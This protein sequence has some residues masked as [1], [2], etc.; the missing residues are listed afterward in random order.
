[1]SRVIDN[2]VAYRIL[3]MLITPFG[4]TEAYHL[5]IIDIHGKA[6]RKV[7]SLTTEAEKDAYTYLHRLVF[8]LKKILNKLPGGESKLKSLVAALWLVKEQYETGKGSTAML[9]EKFAQLL[10]MMD[11]RV[12]LVEEE[13]IVKKFLEEDG[14]AVG[15]APTNSTAGASVNEPKIMPSDVRKYKKGQ[16]TTIAG[17]VRRPAPVN[18]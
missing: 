8:S 3:K 14:G 11:N 4:E 15:G 9:E 5:G 12:S 16:G 2:I 7:S 18:K 10:K 13:I 6:L 1:M 17:M